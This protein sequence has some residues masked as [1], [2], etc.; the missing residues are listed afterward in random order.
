MATCSSTGIL[1]C[2]TAN[3]Y[4]KETSSAGVVSCTSCGTGATACSNK[5]A[6]SCKNGYYLNELS[7][8]V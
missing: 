4:Y 2:N 8:C 6:T 3:G 5:K 1:T 7:E